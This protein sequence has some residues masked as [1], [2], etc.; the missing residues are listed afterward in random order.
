MT[1]GASTFDSPAAADL[2]GSTIDSQWDELGTRFQPPVLIVSTVVGRGMYTLGEALRQRLETCE[3]IEH[4]AIEDYLPPAAVA[5]DLRRYKFISNRLPA[6]LYLVYKLPIVYYRKYLREL[7]WPSNLRS[8]QAKVDAFKPRTVICVSHRPAFWLSTLKRTRGYDFSLWGVLG[9]YG[10]TVGWKYVYWDKMDGFLSPIDRTALT[11]PFPAALAFSTITLPARREYYQLAATQGDPRTVLLVCGYWGQGPFA[12]VVQGLLAVDASVRVV[13]VCGENHSAC[14]TIARRF[15]ADKVRVHGAVESLHPLLRDCGCVVTKPGISTLLE[16]H[17]A[18]RK[19]FLI[20]G[21]PVA[22]DNNA[23][24][25]LQHFGADWFSPAGFRR[26]LD[27]HQRVAAPSVL[28]AGRMDRERDYW[29]DTYRATGSD[30]HKYRWSK[31][32]EGL[33]YVGHHFRRLSATLRNKRVLSLGGG[34]DRLAIDLALAG[35]HVTTVDIAPAAAS[36]TYDLA[37]DAGVLDRLTTMVASAEEA[38]F[39]PGSFD[40]VIFKRALHHMDVGR[41]IRH[42]HGVLASGGLLLAEEP[43]CLPRWLRSVHE[44]FPFHPEA[45]RTTDERELDADDL[46]LIGETFSRATFTYFDCVTRESV[47]YVLYRVR[48]QSLLRPL[49]R[50]DHFLMNHIA[51]ALKQLATYVIIQAVKD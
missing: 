49:G 12:S 7:A 24:Y 48:L 13:V 30:H 40:A 37:R 23:R 47:A 29:D 32:I 36:A 10:D 34:I 17:A 26:W 9:E 25:A 2:V 43:V 28:T 31:Q 20:R 22:E 44:R 33:S 35:N 3:A 21:M 14:E 4:V 18:G 6:L 45:P 1:P 46:R 19:L 11:Y 8:L 42:A 38:T 15:P 50:I 39:A 41:M 5:E 27:S 16:A 51:P